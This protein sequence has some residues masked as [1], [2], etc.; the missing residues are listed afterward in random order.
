M[1]NVQSSTF[2]V[3]DTHEG[4]RPRTWRMGV[5]HAGVGGERGFNAGL[6]VAEIP[7]NSPRRR[8]SRLALRVSVVF[9]ET[10]R[11]GVSVRLRRTRPFAYGS[12]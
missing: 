7:Q 11:F 8:L 6:Y 5:R 1:F 3:A 12:C 4:R 10:L 9:L 2:N